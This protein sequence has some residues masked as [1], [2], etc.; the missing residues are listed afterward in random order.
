MIDNYPEVE[1]AHKSDDLLFGT[2]ESWVAYVR[3]LFPHIDN[4]ITYFLANQTFFKNLLGGVQKGIHISEVTNASRTLLLNTTTLKW[5]PALL[6]FF[7]LRQSILPKLVSTSEVYGQV[8]YGPLSGV[9]IGGLVGDQQAALIGN[10]CL[11]QGEAKCTYGTGAFLLF[12]T[13]GEI[14]K[15]SHGL[16]STVCQHLHYEKSEYCSDIICSF[17]HRLHIKLARKQNLF[18]PSKA[19]VSNCPFKYNLLPLTILM[20]GDLVAVAG[21][22]IKWLRD[23]MA[24]ISSANEVNTLA[25]KESDTGG[26]YFV[27]AFSGLLAP[28]WDPGAAG[29]LIGPSLPLSFPL[30]HF[31]LKQLFYQVYLSILTLHILRVQPLRRTPSRLV[32]SSRA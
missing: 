10:K 2:I 6:E 13:G 16:L 7:G 4:D 30:Q 28:Y 27:T 15:S 31:F 11:N 12:C 1:A 25:A 24:I 18:M 3:V 5:E 9:P 32:P 20:F 19:A 8:A 26:V 29:M 22:A 17:P 21:S 23:S 14:V